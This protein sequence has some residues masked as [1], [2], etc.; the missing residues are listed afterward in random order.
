MTESKLKTYRK[1]PFSL[2]IMGTLR[3]QGH[4]VVVHKRVF[5]T[6]K[7]KGVNFGYLLTE[8]ILSER[9]HVVYD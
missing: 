7:K 8:P 6:G 4:F 3:L 1:A 2:F 5:F 9:R